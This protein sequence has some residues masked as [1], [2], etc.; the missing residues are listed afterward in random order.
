MIRR[1]LF[2]AALT[3]V[4]CLYGAKGG[5]DEKVLLNHLRQTSKAF[6]DAVN[7][8]TEA[9][10]K[11]KPSPERWSI[12][13]CAEHI[14]LSEDFLRGIVEKKVLTGPSGTQSPE[15]RK[16]LDEKVLRMVTD[17]SS[18][19]KAPEPVAPKSTLAPKAALAHFKQSRKKTADLAK[20]ADLRDHA[21]SHPAF[22]ELDA[23]QW[24]LF[25]SGHTARH[26][27]QI[28]EVKADPGFPK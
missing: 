21:A 4:P 7:G 13:E 28:L 5:E 27:A 14:A 20:R 16:Q 3:V 12:A 19:F 17:R 6:F 22:K 23:H 10:W 26:T 8:L 2:I 15:D 1:N 9:Q 25:L 11:Y 18:K 24:L